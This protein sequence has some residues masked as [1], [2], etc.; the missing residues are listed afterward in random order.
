MTTAERQL[1]WIWGGLVL[2]IAALSPV[3][4]LLAP[5]LRP[6]IFRSVTGAPCPSCGATRGVLALM[7]GRVIDAFV[8]NPLVMTAVLALAVGGVF[9]PIWAWRSGKIPS[10]SNPIPMWLRIG[11]VALILTN[12]LWLIATQ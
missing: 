8:F 9:A 4:V 5:W 10:I 12:W 6:C 11:I 7:D 1:A 2:A 3:W